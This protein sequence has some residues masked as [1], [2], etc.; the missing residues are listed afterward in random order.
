MTCGPP[1]LITIVVLVISQLVASAAAISWSNTS[2]RTASNVPYV[3]VP[4][5]GEHFAPVMLRLSSLGVLGRGPQP[6]STQYE[7]KIAE[8][9]GKKPWDGDTVYADALVMYK[10]ERIG[11]SG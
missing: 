9:T 11:S 1:H 2:R 4:M 6:T 3:D 5:V 10:G 8:M 7:R